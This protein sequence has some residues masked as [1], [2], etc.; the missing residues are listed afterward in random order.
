MSGGILPVLSFGLVAVTA[1]ALMLLAMVH[2]ELAP[3]A[4]LFAKRRWLLATA[5]GS[6]ILAFAFK[7]AIIATVA[8]YPHLLI[9]SLAD[10]TDT[11]SVSTTPLPMVF[12]YRFVP[13]ETGQAAGISRLPTTDYTWQAL[14]EQP[15]EPVGNRGN[16][17][18][19]ALGEQLFFDKNLSRDGTLACA[20]CHDL[21]GKAGADGRATSLGIDG[22]HG[23]RNAPTVWNAAFQAALF[24]DGR[25]D[26]LEAQAKGPLLNPLEMGMPTFA[27]VEER[28]NARA[29]YRQ[30]FDAAFGAGTPITIE[31]IAEALA[32]YERTLITPDTP[33]DR[34]VRGERDA[35]TPAQLRGMA[36]FQSLGC[37][38][39]HFGP[40]FSAA[41]VFDRRMPLRPFP[42]NPTPY[43]ARYELLADRGASS[44]ERG[45]WRVPSLRNVALTGPWFHNGSV[46][47]LEEAV[48]IMAS[49]QLGYSGNYLV[50]SSG[51]GRLREI[52]RPVLSEQQVSDIVAFLKALSS[53]RLARQSQTASARR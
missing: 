12:S 10:N 35:L 38:T 39:C 3:A 48:R 33:Y 2:F 27:A 53:E 24:W 13:L 28:V 26:S 52:D 44:N 29:A 36:L 50:W 45:V 19:V 4:R 22:Q 49:V 47:R 6:G 34:F 41:S 8:H 5:L 25:A 31:R 1:A 11:G 23:R 9:S 32:A 51:E 40:N 30:A 20:S 15:P 37:I 7:L 16:P 46:T 42:L 43:E 14:P 17:A 21:L 18:K